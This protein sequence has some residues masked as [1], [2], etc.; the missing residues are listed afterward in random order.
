MN[1][2][3]A[4]SPLRVEQIK[5]HAHVAE[6][7]R[8]RCLVDTAAAATAS[9]SGLELKADVGSGCCH[10]GRPEASAPPASGPSTGEDP[11]V[12]EIRLV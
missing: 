7:L 3:D 11:R 8:T 1:E 12:A 4:Q 2:H 10:R 9:D 6:L 5:T